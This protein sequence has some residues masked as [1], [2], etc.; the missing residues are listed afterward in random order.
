MSSTVKAKPGKTVKIAAVAII[1]GFLVSCSQ[2]VLTGLN[3][4]DAL[5]AQVVLQR[6]GI[7]ATVSVDKNGIYTIST[8]SDGHSKA[9]E[10]LTDA[11]LPH[12]RHAS[13]ADI[14]P[15]GGFLVT[16]FEQK[17]RMNYALEQQLS[18]T[19]TELDGVESARVHVVL[20]EDNGRGL[21]KERARASALLTYRPNA[22]LANIETK[23]RALLVNSIRGLSYEDVSVVAT[24]W[25]E[26]GDVQPTS[27]PTEQ[28]T[29]IMQTIFGSDYK[30]TFIVAAAVLLALAAAL[31]LLLPQRKES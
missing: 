7:D 10:L 17:A 4:R 29:S 28:T 27:L 31:L 2:D 23:S 14:F 20:A 22:D 30:R 21:I 13:V 9:I 19:L 24:P 3:Q 25:T 26:P 6:A 5:D 16:P 1:C 15:G 12:Q 8:A 18:E 11:G